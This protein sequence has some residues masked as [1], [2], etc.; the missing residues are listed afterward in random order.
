W[1]M[2]SASGFSRLILRMNR[3]VSR[4]SLSG[5]LGLPTT[6]ENSG[7]MPNCRMRAASSSVCSAFT[8]LFICSS[9]QSEP[10][11]APKK[12]MAEPAGCKVRKV[13]SEYRNDASLAPPAQPQ[14]NQLFGELGRMPF[15]QEEVVVVKL[16]R[17]DLKSLLQIL[18]HCGR[19]LR[20]FCFLPRSIHRHHAAKTT[21][22]RAADA[23]LMDSRSLAQKCRQNVI[24]GIRQLL[25]RQP[26]KIVRRA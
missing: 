21:A 17:I 15:V 5:S 13:L 8:P 10:D 6:K 12:I 1:T 25:V 7:T 14:R 3:I 2:I 19:S 26:G 18:K 24:P 9:T 4:V 20:V 16:H 22:K 11:S 23:G